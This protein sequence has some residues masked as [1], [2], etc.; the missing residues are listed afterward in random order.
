MYSQAIP[1]EGDL[2]QKHPQPAEA[3]ARGI[4]AHSY[5]CMRDSDGQQALQPLPSHMEVGPQASASHAVGSLH[6]ESVPVGRPT[7]RLTCPASPLLW[8]VQEHRMV[9]LH[10]GLYMLP[11]PSEPQELVQE[12]VP[13][14]QHL[15]AGPGPTQA[16][17]APHSL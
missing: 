12:H 13:N 15:A 5:F 8:L 9:G 16:H 14:S 17:K 3:A 2:L 10:T 11:T 6:D 1:S 7:H 4:T